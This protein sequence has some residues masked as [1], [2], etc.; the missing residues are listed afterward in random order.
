MISDK[1]DEIIKELFKSLI[2]NYQQVLEN[3]MKG[4]DIIFDSVDG[5]RCLCHKI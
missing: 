1:T 4:S 5:L 2:S 3:K